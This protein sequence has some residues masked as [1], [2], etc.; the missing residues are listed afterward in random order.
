METDAGL[1]M[2]KNYPKFSAL[3]PHKIPKKIWQIRDRQYV[4]IEGVEA[5]V[6]EAAAVEAAVEAGVSNSK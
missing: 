2:K 5:V 3:A 6:V 4:Q 1:D